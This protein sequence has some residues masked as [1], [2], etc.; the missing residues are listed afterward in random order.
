M[1]QP[2][3]R[4]PCPTSKQLQALGF[5][6]GVNCPHYVED[7]D[8]N[9]VASVCVLSY[10][11]AGFWAGEF[12]QGIA[13]LSSEATSKPYTLHKQE[14]RKSLY[15][16]K[17]P[18]LADVFHSIL[19]DGDSADVANFAEWCGGLGYSSDSIKALETFKE[20]E[21][22]A[23]ALRKVPADALARA[24]EILTDY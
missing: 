19:L 14:L 3:K 11:G 13:C 18:T 6:L 4:K 20:C 9:R 8:W 21:R 22:I 12:R 24:R 5:A 23:K 17:P 2:M 1:Q 15:G 7:K 16:Y 10:N